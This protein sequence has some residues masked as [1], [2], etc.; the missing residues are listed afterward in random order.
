M[1]I[2]VLNSVRP[3]LLAPCSGPHAPLSPKVP[4]TVTLSRGRYQAA[5]WRGGKIVHLGAFTTAEEAALAYARTPEA[6]RQAA[7]QAAQA[8]EADDE[9]DEVAE[10]AVSYTH[11]TLPTILLV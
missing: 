9:V 10:V 5:V 11:L 8:A 7:A 2:H 4:Q 3:E 1:G 6:R